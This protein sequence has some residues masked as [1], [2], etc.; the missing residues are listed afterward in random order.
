LSTLR[1]SSN[2]HFAPTDNKR[3]ALLCGQCDEHLR[4]IEKNLGV[5]ILNRGNHFQI[6]GAPKAVHIANQVLNS[7]YQQT[8]HDPDLNPSKIYLC[9]QEVNG[10]KGKHKNKSSEKKWQLNTQKQ[11]FT[12]LN[13]N[14]QR[15]LANIEA[16]NINFAV[17]PAGTG[18]TFLAVA[19]AVA[20]LEKHQV[21]RIVLVRPAVEAGEQL[22]FLPGDLAQKVDP[23]LRPIYDALYE[24]LG[25]ETCIKYIEHNIIEIAPLA[26]MRGRTLSDSF[27]ILDE[28]QN[29]TK[30]QM[31]MFLTRLGFGSTAVITGDI[32]QIDL[33]TGQ[34]SGLCHALEIL[35]SIKGIS[36]TFFQ[37]NDSVRHELV[38]RI[39]EAYEKN[40]AVKRDQ[41]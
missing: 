35:Q 21:N 28:A 3:L 40:E 9:I 14:Q 37:A 1:Q 32:T 33:P 5:E 24:M 8:Q 26:Y 39:I 31:K 19:T 41:K 38:S 7:I 23:Y 22:G 27:V 6:N 12:A 11:T 18:K 17:G 20:A 4:L 29:A 25:Y 16:H 2:L 36:F 34:Y 15:Y 30:K 13:K 10:T